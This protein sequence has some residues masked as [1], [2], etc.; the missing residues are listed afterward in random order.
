[1]WVDFYS[2][3]DNRTYE[4]NLSA[5][6]YIS[7]PRETLKQMKD[8]LEYEAVGRIYEAVCEYIYDDKEPSLKD[9]AEKSFFNTIIEQIA[10]LSFNYLKKISRLKNQNGKLK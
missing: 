7:I 3:E 8:I 2:V 9:K 10:R 1:M 5:L 6:P 4:L